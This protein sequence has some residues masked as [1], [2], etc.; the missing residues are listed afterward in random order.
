MNF[1]I[2][3]F[4]NQIRSPAITTQFLSDENTLDGYLQASKIHFE[5]NNCKLISSKALAINARSKNACKNKRMNITARRSRE[6]HNKL[7]T[8]LTTLIVAPE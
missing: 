2:L 1:R 6:Q 5:N 3:L 4:V 8:Y 7:L